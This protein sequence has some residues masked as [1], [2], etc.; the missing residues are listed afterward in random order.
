MSLPLK[1]IYKMI[2]TRAT[3]DTG[4]GGLFNTTTPLITGWYTR[5][6]PANSAL[7]YVVVNLIDAGNNDGL[8][9]SLRRIIVRFSLF[10]AGNAENAIDTIRARILGNW[11]TSTGRIPT[12]GFDRWTGT[13]TDTTFKMSPMI[14]IN[15]TELFEERVTQTI[16]EMETYVSKQATSP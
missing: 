16:F 3:S 7:P 5:L 1:D 11:L 12:V 9:F 4:T 13:L 6:A 2:R 15:Q 10:T 14:F 8:A